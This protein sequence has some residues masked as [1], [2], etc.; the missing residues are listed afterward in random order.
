MYISFDRPPGQMTN[1]RNNHISPTFQSFPADT[2]SL[3]RI[4]QK[5]DHQ[6]ANPQLSYDA[7]PN[8]Q[9]Y[10]K[11]WFFFKKLENVSYE[12]VSV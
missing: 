3:T 6:F 1:Q 9:S 12:H 2:V 5:I 10:V 8:H 7:E 11:T 4:L